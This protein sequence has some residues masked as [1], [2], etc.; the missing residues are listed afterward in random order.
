MRNYEDILSLLNNEGRLRTIPETKTSGVVDFSSN[1]YMGLAKRKDLVA[2]FLEEH[3]S[4]QFT[5]AAS[6]LLASCQEEYEKL[7]KWLSSAYNKDV[8]L[9]NSGYHANVGTMSALAS[10]DTLVVAD[11]LVHASIIDG[12]VLSKAPFKRFRHNDMEQLR[13]IVAENINKYKQLLVVTESVFSMDGDEVPFEDLI[14]IKKAYPSVMLYVDEAHALGVRGHRGLG[15]AEEKGFLEYVDVLIGTFGKACASMGAFVATSTV[16]KSYLINASRSFIFSTALPPVNVDW[17]LFMLHTLEKM[18]AERNYLMELSVRFRRGMET[19][20]GE[21]NISSTQI[22]PWLIGNSTRAVE[23]SKKL[24]ER[25]IV[26]LPIR[27]P[28]VPAGTE[29]IRFSLSASMT[30]SQVDNLLMAISEII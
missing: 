16:I 22:V 10:S 7:E 4:L 6:R 17:T 9:Y 25:G 5:S 8:L 28:T 12:I 26:A 21:K 27:K 13:T 20:T 24:C 14:E 3:R 2:K 11:K 15:I 30:I 1:D 23:L 29:R 18:N 19:L